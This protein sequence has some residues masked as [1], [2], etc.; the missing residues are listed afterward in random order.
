MGTSF[1]FACIRLWSRLNDGLLCVPAGVAWRGQQHTDM[2]IPDVWGFADQSQDFQVGHRSILSLITSELVIILSPYQSISLP[3]P[4]ASF[5]NRE[6]MLSLPDALSALSLCSL[7][8][9]NEMCFCM[10]TRGS[11]TT[12]GHHPLFIWYFDFGKIIEI[13]FHGDTD[14]VYRI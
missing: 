1:G 12:T 4:E 5:W 6:E 8:T 14:H 10:R 11:S 2:V 13:F 7:R 3:N 9:Y